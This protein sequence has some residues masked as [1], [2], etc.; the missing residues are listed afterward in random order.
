MFEE[1]VELKNK[2]IVTI[3]LIATKDNFIVCAV[4]ENNKIVGKCVFEIVT[5]EIKSISSPK[6]NGQEK[7]LIKD[8]NIL[9]GN[10]N[11]SIV[12]QEFI[13][14]NNL[15]IGSNLS[16]CK[17][18]QIEIL[19]E[20]FFKV[21]LGTLMIKKMEEFAVSKNCQ[22]ISGWFYPNGNFWYGASSFYSKNGFNFIKDEKG[23]THITKTLQASK[24]K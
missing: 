18:S 20:D 1:K 2:K 22:K 24:E 13:K 9:N 8:K 12:S 21:G 4:D 23:I 7:Y 17:L 6:F 10:I 15:K 5:R 19:S 14:E 3:G 16:I 11:S